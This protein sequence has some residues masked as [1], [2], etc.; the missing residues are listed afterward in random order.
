MIKILNIPILVF[1]LLMLFYKIKLKA[2]KTKIGKK[3]LLFSH[4]NKIF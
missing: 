4:F 1:L 3:I 2:K